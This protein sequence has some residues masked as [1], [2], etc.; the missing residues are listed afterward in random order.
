MFSQSIREQ[1]IKTPLAFPEQEAPLKRVK[2]IPFKLSCPIFSYIKLPIERCMAEDA[3]LRLMLVMSECEEWAQESAE[4]RYSLL[5]SLHDQLQAFP[6]VFSIETAVGPL[7]ETAVSYANTFNIDEI[8]LTN[9][10]TSAKIQQK[11][12]CKTTPLHLN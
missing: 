7:V 4:E 5:R 11:A 8:F 6:L 10:D 9:N 2:L 1:R 12:L 3:E